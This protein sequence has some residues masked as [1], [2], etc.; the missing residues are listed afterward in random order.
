MDSTISG[1]LDG[2]STRRPSHWAG[3]QRVLI[4]GIV[5]GLA[6]GVALCGVGL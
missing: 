1:A 2:P 5:P 3:E 4:L 6:N